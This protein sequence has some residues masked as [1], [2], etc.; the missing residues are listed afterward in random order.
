[1][2]ANEFSVVSSAMD[3]CRRLIAAG[4]IQRWDVV[5]WGVSANLA[6]AALSVSL[7]PQTF[8]RSFALFILAAAASIAAWFLMRY[9]NQRMTRARGDAIHLSRVFK[10]G[11][12]K[13]DELVGHDSEEAYSAGTAYDREEL[14]TFGAILAVVPFLTL[15]RYLIER[16]L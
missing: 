10:K 15:A 9:Y 3:D 11:G 2:D 6:L 12:I 7:T 14:T 16:S 1:M 5:K 4:K 8:G 13:F